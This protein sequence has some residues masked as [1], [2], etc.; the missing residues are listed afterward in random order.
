MAKYIIKRI[1]L[2]IL[3]LFGVSLI[4]Y[5][6][7]R[8][9]PMNYIESKFLTLKQT[10]GL[11]DEDYANLLALYGLDDDSFLGILK[12]YW[13]WLSNFLQGD[14]GKSW[15]FTIPVTE[16]IG[17]KMG[18]S[19]AVAFVSLIIEMLIAIPLGIKCACNQYGK[20]DYIVTFLCMI[21]ISFP[22]FF[23]GNMF[24]KWFAV[25]LGWFDVLGGLGEGGL[26]ASPK[27]SITPSSLKKSWSIFINCVIFILLIFST[28]TGVPS[29]HSAQSARNLYISFFALG[30]F[31]IR[32]LETFIITVIP[33]ESASLF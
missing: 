21:G 11:S 27:K 33:T 1:L 23:L 8:C 7:V 2:A 9:M 13:N 15:K 24:I 3:I 32:N 17:S 19:F 30:S 18:V 4:L 28:V 14:L 22:S 16:V 29:S 31:F 26:A 6:L 25:D 5:I 20:L 10:N 12:G